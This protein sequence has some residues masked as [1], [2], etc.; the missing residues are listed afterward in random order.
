MN[1]TRGRAAGPAEAA[2]RPA[3]AAGLVLL[4]Q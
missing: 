1:A 2:A 3:G 4:L